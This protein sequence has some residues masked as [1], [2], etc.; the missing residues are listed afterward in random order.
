MAEAVVSFAVETI[1]NLL[2]EE[3]KF[4][5]GVSDQVE[6]L[7]LELDQLRSFLRDAD[8]KQQQH[9]EETVKVWIS[10]A[11]DL[12]YAAEDLLESYAFKVASRRGRDMR[13]IVKNC[14]CILNKCY[15]GRKIGKE[16][17]TLKAKISDLTK[18]FHEYGIRAKMERDGGTSS[19]EQQ[20]RRTYSRVIEDDFVGLKDD[21]GLIVEKLV[22]EDEIH[23]HLRVVSI[24]GMGGLGKT[25]LAQK[26][27]NHPRVKRYFDICTWVCVSQKWQKEDMLQQILFSLIPER[28]KEILKWRDEELV[29]QLFQILQSKKYFLVLDDIWSIEA[30]ECIKQAFPIKKDGSKIL[31][32]TRNKDVA[33]QIDPNGFHHQPRLLTE[34]ECWELL[35]MKA[36]RERFEGDMQKLEI[37]GKEMVK[38]CGGLPLGVIVLGGTLATKK[39]LNEWEVV[40]K[41]IKAHLGRGKNLIEEQGNVHKILALSY[42]DLPQKLKPCFLYL[43]KFD[44]DSDIDAETLYQLWI[45]EGM[46]SVKDRIGEE[47]MMD[48]AERYLGELVQRCMVEGI[49]PETPSILRSLSSCRLHDLMRDLS[50]LKATEENF[51]LSISYGDGFDDDTTNNSS[52]SHL[53]QVYRLVIRLPKESVPKY[54]PLEKR[55]T[56]HLRSLSLLVLDDYEGRL[57]RTMKSQFNRFKMLRV[58]SIEG[59]CP[60]EPVDDT[61]K[62]FFNETIDH[63]RLPK[64]IGKLIHLRYL[65]LRRS[66]FV[67]L[68]SSIGNLQHLQTLD[69]RGV[70]LKIPN[71]LSKMRQLRHLY[72]SENHLAP[73]RLVNIMFCKLR[74]N[75]LNKLETLENFCIPFCHIKDVSKLKNLR[76]LSAKIHMD[77]GDPTEIIGYMSN[78]EH[79]RRT[80]L[81]IISKEDS[82]TMNEKLSLVVGECL[83]CCN[84]QRLKVMGSFGNLP[85]YEDHFCR[86]LTTLELKMSKITEDP[87]K[88]LEIFPNLQ[89]LSFFWDSFVG[90]EMRCTASGFRQLRSLYLGHLSNLEQWWIDDG[91]MP[92]LLDLTIAQ[93]RKLEMIPNG[94]RSISTLQQLK[95]M[96]MPREFEDRIRAVDGREGADFHKI[97]HIPSVI[98]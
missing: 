24:S 97:S 7:Q 61:R 53:L 55:I 69:L 30:W 16:I 63:L 77:Y 19:L 93:C 47:S 49:D 48:V 78:L 51:L 41:N 26:V 76:A 79:L 91:A 66:L 96:L 21:V 33:V 37:L 1:G 71:V 58:L 87:M 50:L 98:I 62:D 14:V 46:I 68:P 89:K 4:L 73:G 60:S 6:Q 13:S 74:L 85:R 20:L 25:T 54:V 39:S 31:L 15:A 40:H 44:E 36:L 10:Q 38:Y 82:T 22:M 80:S 75:R 94:L 92:N 70:V 64:A 67:C 86:R 65:S 2:I 9:E 11:R 95:V 34:D 57:P 23:R 52:L 72:L 18:R 17:Q 35:K 28:R 12:A 32:T 5:H 27:Y 3:A 8:A 83:S 90:T 84:L 29:R 59:L 43:G 42:N 56:R 81:S 45:A 88:T